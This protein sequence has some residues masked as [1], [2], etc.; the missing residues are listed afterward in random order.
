MTAGRIA[1][2]IAVLV[3]AFSAVLIAP[4]PAAAGGAKH[5]PLSDFLAA[6]GTT[7]LNS[8]PVPDYIAW[9]GR[10]PDYL[11]LG[12]MDYA[13]ISDAWLVSQGHASVGTQ[14][15]GSFLRRD[16]GGGKY[17]Y[18]VDIHTTDAISFMLPNPS[19]AQATDPL[20]FGARAQDIKAGAT[21]SLGECHFRF[22]WRENAGAPIADAFGVVT[23]IL[24]D[25]FELVEIS[26]RGRATGAL[27]ATSGL[28]EGT[29]GEMIISE[30]GLFQTGF[31]GA[32]SDGFPA[33]LVDLH[34][35]GQ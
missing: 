17:E 3:L 29:P 2:T 9:T 25:G 10:P 1:R 11:H 28:G 19:T 31:H 12:S 5:L 30:T 34:V 13:G 6:Q 20:L 24:P 18:E 15:S 21:P 33:E 14:V 35:I 27:H 7:V 8:P 22:V 4:T 32:T 23:G 16:I 26:I